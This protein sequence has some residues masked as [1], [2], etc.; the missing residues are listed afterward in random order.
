MKKTVLVTGGTAKDAPAMAAL[1]LNIKHTNNN[2]T[3]DI[4]IFHD[5]ISNS[6]QT[7]MKKIMPV[8]FRLYNYSGNTENFKDTVN[9]YFSTMIFC[10][11]E[12]FNLLNEYRAVIWTDYDVVINNDI[13]ELLTVSSSGFKMMPDI[14]LTVRAMFDK[15]IN[16]T[17]ENYK[18]DIL[19]ICTPLFL[20]F[21]NMIKYNEYYRYCIEQT[22]RFAQYLYMPEQ[23]IINLLLQD[24]NIQYDPIDYKT[25]CAHPYYEK[26][27]E[28][29]KIIHSY[30]KPKFWN[31]LYNA[32]WEKNYRTWIKM[33][34]SKYFH[35][36]FSY[37]PKIKF[38]KLISLIQKTTK[39]L[40]PSPVYRHIRNQYQMFFK[41]IFDKIN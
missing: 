32:V 12:C 35:R 22:N 26:I 9:N 27:T 18:L 4:I 16:D 24:Y 13:S 37:I 34:G 40:L 21:D 39:L 1:L 2:L 5:G 38:K 7:I 8:Q 17:I 30:A 31:G 23:C 6:D 14:S 33:G 19:G 20:L 3:D 11:Y 10:K 28:Y 36:K 29:T 41:N 25:Y 15:E